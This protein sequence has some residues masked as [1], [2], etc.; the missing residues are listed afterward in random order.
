MMSFFARLLENKQQ[1]I[2]LGGFSV[3]Y[4]RLFGVFLLIFCCSKHISQ[5]MVTADGD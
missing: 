2:C 5:Q 4:L 3:D 1:I